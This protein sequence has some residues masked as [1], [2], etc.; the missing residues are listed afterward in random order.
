MLV[1]MGLCAAF[2]TAARVA[3]RRWETL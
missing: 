3:A 1:L 2:L